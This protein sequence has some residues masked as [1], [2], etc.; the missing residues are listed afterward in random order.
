M[1][2]ITVIIVLLISLWIFYYGLF[3]R[4]LKTIIKK[5]IYKLD[6]LDFNSRIDN[7][8]L[9]LNIT[10]DDINVSIIQ[11]IKILGIQIEKFNIC[12]FTIYIKKH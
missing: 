3:T 12:V 4:D 5:L 10:S 9:K 1:S 2:N 11:L 8:I 7:I 6:E